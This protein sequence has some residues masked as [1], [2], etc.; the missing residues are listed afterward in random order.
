MSTATKK[1]VLSSIQKAMNQLDACFEKIH[2]AAQVINKRDRLDA[3]VNELFACRLITKH[4]F[5]AEARRK[6]KPVKIK[7]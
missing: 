1:P 5:S 2:A 4:V 3:V 6:A 7:E